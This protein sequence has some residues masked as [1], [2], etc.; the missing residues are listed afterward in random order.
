M[1][2]LSLSTLNIPES[3]RIIAEMKNF[4]GDQENVVS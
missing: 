1:P 2:M 3:A 4:Q